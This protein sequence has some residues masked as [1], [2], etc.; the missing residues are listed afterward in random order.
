M[1]RAYNEYVISVSIYGT[2]NKM[3]RFYMD[4]LFA[5]NFPLNA[6][7]LFFLSPNRVVTVS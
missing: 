4:L 7:R 5:R 1:Y 2:N 6:S 3:F